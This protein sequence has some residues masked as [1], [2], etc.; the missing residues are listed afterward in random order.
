IALGAFAAN[1]TS[2]PLLA[3]VLIATG[4]TASGVLGAWLLRDVARIAI[5]LPRL[6]D[7]LSLLFIGASLTPAITA[8]LGAASLC[9]AEIHPWSSYFSLWSLWWFGD[10][11]GVIII[12][13]LLLTWSSLFAKERESGDIADYGLLAV[14]LLFLGFLIFQPDSAIATILPARIL[15]FPF[16]IWAALRLGAAGS[17]LGVFAISIMAAIPALRAI[18]PFGHEAGEN[19]ISLQIFMCVVAIMGLVIA[20]ANSER[21]E[22]ERALHESREQIRYTLEAAK[23]GTWD[24]DIRSGVVHWSEV[25]EEIQGIPWDR[26]GGRIEDFFERVCSKD[27]DRIR[28][29]IGNALSQGKLY[30]VEYRQIHPDGRTQWLEG[31]GRAFY[32]QEG[33]P[34]GMRGICMDISERKELE[35]ELKQLTDNL[36]NQ[37]LERTAMAEKR[38][39]ELQK[40]AMALTQTENRE[41]RR[42]A[43]TLHDGLQQ[44]FV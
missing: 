38:A 23:V 41:R 43:H 26:D 14:S 36:E 31:K 8:T 17:S 7:C 18:E 3:A 24:W 44:L 27:R 10:G 34:V 2:G 20:A 21:R 42:L 32:D 1:A 11:A 25:M 12:C 35:L 37:V 6:K 30:Q 15:V 13:P 4:N 39:A 33:R 9:L 28:R 5:S 29:A 40:M 19:L 16:V 22:N